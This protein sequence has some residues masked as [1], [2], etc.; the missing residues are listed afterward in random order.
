M[1]LP[2]EPDYEGQMGRGKHS[3]SSSVAEEAAN[4]VTERVARALEALLGNDAS[5]QE[6][7]VEIAKL[8]Q[9]RPTEVA[10]LRLQKGFLKF[11]FPAELRTVGAI[12]LSSS[13]AVAAHTATT[14]RRELFNTFS[15]VKHAGVFES[16]RLAKTES[17]DAA[18]IQKLM[19]APIMDKA[20]NVLGVVQI[21][22]K[23][24]AATSCGADFTSDDLQQLEAAARL[25]AKARFMQPE[26]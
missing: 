3:G 23:G 6:F 4:S 9:V 13:S 15:K 2:A 8:F 7:C 18:P 1:K 26:A 16:V 17:A 5:E 11:V 22:R 10:L 20:G 24:L 25:L 14:K 21:C 19:S 12:P